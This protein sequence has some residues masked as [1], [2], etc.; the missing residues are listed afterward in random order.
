MGTLSRGVL[1]LRAPA[2]ALGLGVGSKLFSV[3]GFATAAPSESDLTA[4]LVTN[5]A[6][7]VDATPPFDATL[8]MQQEQ[9]LVAVDCTDQNITEFGG[10]HTLNDIR[11]G[12][13][14]LCRNVGANK[15]NSGAFMQFQF[16][17]SAIDVIVAKGPRG[18]NFNL[19]LDGGTP[20]KVDLFRPPS[21]PT[22]PDNSGRKDLDFGVTFHRDLTP[23]T[24]T[25]RVDVLN[26]DPDPLRD[27]VYI[28][29]FR[30]TGGDIV[31]PSSTGSGDTANVV[32]A[33]VA[34]GATTVVA[35]VT[36]IGTRNLAAVLEA[37]DDVVMEVH[38]ASGMLLA[39]A[40]GAGGVTSVNI[41]PVSVG[42]YLVTLHNTGAT[43]A[44]FT[45]WEVLSEQ[46]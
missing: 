25:L 6:R 39:T 12:E 29:G 30:I 28:D 37:G 2:S 19:S 34:A 17:G 36:D 32:T 13:G 1:T 43:D 5:S 24:H 23:G 9:P 8:V 20:T 10:W 4:G 11:A 31:T 18:G 35:V 7:T 40:T 33:T 21:D 38:D 16:T 44:P 26:D 22:H 14:T 15:G 41:G 45:L 27:M 42:T 46:R 3:T